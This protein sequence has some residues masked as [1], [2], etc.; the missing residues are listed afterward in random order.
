[1]LPP[2]QN[3]GILEVFSEI[4]GFRREFDLLL[5]F[6]LFHSETTRLFWF[7]IILWCFGLEHFTTSGKCFSSIRIFYQK[8]INYGPGR[9]NLVRGGPWR[10]DNFFSESQN[11]WKN[12]LHDYLLFRIYCKCNCFM[13]PWLFTKVG[14]QTNNALKVAKMHR[15]TL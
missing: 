10:P 3:F 2:G 13:R 11:I 9:I 5:V 12:I 8:Y 4:S 7:E 6:S 1:M 14:F 15:F